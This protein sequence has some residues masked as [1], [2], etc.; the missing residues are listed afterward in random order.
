MITK[1]KIFEQKRDIPK[2]G[3][4][5]KFDWRYFID[6]FFKT[7]IGQIVSIST[8]EKNIDMESANKYFVVKFDERNPMNNSYINRFSGYEF[9][10]WNSDRRILELE[11]DIIKYNL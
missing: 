4:Y 5:V 7:A 9:S 11:D 2:V 10:D 3:D 1:F 6:D 8:N